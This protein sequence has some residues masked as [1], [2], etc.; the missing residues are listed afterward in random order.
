LIL[1]AGRQRSPEFPWR[2][3]GVW[4]WLGYC[5]LSLLSIIPA[6]EKVY[7]LMAAVKFA[8]FILIYIAAYHALRDE[9]DLRWMFHTIAAMLILQAGWR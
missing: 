4:L 6:M 9:T 1:S 3:P 2:P 5:G 8:K 7:V